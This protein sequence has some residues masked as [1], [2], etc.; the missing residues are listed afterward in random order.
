M[1]IVKAII[2]FF[3]GRILRFLTQIYFVD[4]SDLQLAN[5]KLLKC[6]TFI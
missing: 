2:Y 5:K 4:V 6:V 3:F 1:T